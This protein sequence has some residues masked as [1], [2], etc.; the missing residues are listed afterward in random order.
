MMTC[1]GTLNGFLGSSKVLVAHGCHL[2]HGR[3]IA[4]VDHFACCKLAG[5]MP[6]RVSSKRSI[7]ITECRRKI[8][9]DET[10]GAP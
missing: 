9:I 7:T 8:E 10:F 2:A 4:I 5:D 6:W 1:R 3:L